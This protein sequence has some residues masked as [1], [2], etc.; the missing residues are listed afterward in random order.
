M[1]YT[2]LHACGASRTASNQGLF[3]MRYMFAFLALLLSFAAVAAPEQMFV[4]EIRVMKLAPIERVA[5]GNSSIL[6]TSLLKNGQLLILAETAGNT[7]VRIWFEDGRESQFQVNVHE[8][9]LANSARALNEIF[10]NIKG[11][12]AENVGEQVVLR[13]ELYP[14]YAPIVEKVLEKFPNVIN[15]TNAA[16]KIIGQML[17]GIDGTNVG[18]VGKHVVLR[19]EFDPKHQPVIDEILKR[20]PDLVNLAHPANVLPQDKMVFMNVKITEF[21]KSKLENLGI[22]W[23]NPISGPSAAFAVDVAA[24]KTFRVTP[25]TPAFSNGLPVDLT[26][27]PLGYFGIATE[28]SS[29]INFLVNSGDAL[30]LAEPRLSTRSGGEAKFLAGGEIPLPTTGSLGQSNVEFKEFGISMNIKPVVDRDDNILATVSTELSA[31]D[32]SVA[33]DGIP[34]FLTR[35]TETDISIR[36]GQTLVISGLINQEAAKDINGL[37]GFSEIPILGALFRSKNFRNRV[38]ELVI[39]VTPTVYDADSEINKSHL[40][41]ARANVGKFV[42]SVNE[43]S[44]DIV[45]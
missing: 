20:F 45:E 32:N 31:V 15:L 36:S 12:K 37:K 39:F 4:G 16:D 35:R 28:I 10:A 5:V 23:D 18:I 8:N 38:T 41:R 6:S 44:L 2:T 30:I 7:D 40:E 3:T 29:R 11:I 13:G 43:K 21:N 24:N 33:V 42:G 1:T 34:G 22:D 14:E 9:D 19:G 17:Q 25:A 27:S 26:T